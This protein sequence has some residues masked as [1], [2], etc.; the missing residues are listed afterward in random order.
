MAAPLPFA[1]EIETFAHSHTLD[2]RLVSAVVAQ[3]SL[4]RPRA[5][6][7]EP[8]FWERY[9]KRNPLYRDLDPERVSASYGLMQI[10]YV[11]AV[12]MG[13]PYRDPEYLFVPSINLEY[14]C[15]KLRQLLDWSNGSRAQALAAYNGGKGGNTVLPYRNQAYADAVLVKLEGLEKG[16]GGPAPP[17]SA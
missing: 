5:Y 14:G 4:Y 8:G 16:M 9:M 12:E 6:R 15:R 10:M 13:F 3:E 1:I 7:Y 11:V 2:P 17:K